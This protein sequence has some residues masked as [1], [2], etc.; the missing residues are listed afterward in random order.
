MEIIIKEKEIPENKS[1]SKS[2]E[3]VPKKKK[4]KG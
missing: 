2:S 4:E 1:K 3:K